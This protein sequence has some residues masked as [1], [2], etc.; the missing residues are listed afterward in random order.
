MSANKA[1]EDNFFYVAEIKCLRGI[2]ASCLY[3]IKTTVRRGLV[4]MDQTQKVD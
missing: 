2:M 1:N 3:D 4:Q